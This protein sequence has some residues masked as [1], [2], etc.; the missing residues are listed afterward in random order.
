M[1]NTYPSTYSLA[2]AAIVLTAGLLCSTAS[3]ETWREH[4]FDD[5]RKGESDDG[6]VN[7]YAAADG[8]LRTVY[9]FDYNR[10]GSN[11][12]LY[13]C[14]HDNGYAPPAYI[15]MNNDGRFDPRFRWELLNE[16]SR[17]GTIADLNGDGWPEVILCGTMNGMNFGKLDSLV[18]YGDPK[19]YARARSTRLPTSSSH[20][21]V[22]IDVNND[23]NPDLAFAQGS[24][25]GVVVY[26][27]RDGAFNPTD[28]KTLGVGPVSW[29]QTAD[30][31]GDKR[32]DLLVLTGGRLLGFAVNGDGIE[33]D[34]SLDIDVRGSGRF[35]VADVDGDGLMDIVVTDKKNKAGGVLIYWGDAD[36]SF[37][38]RPP[39]LL[40]SVF[41]RDVAVA[42]L[43]R[44][45]HPDVVV[46]N[47]GNDN[48]DGDTPTTIYFG[49]G[50]G[51]DPDSPY[52]LQTRFAAGVS[53]ADFDGDG[54]E[55]LV[56]ACTRSDSSHNVSSYIYYN[57]EG[58]FSDS[59]RTAV[60][61][62]GA[63]QTAVGDVDRNGRP[64]VMFLNSVDGTKGLSDA[65]LYWND[66]EGHFTAERMSLLPIRDAFG[67]VAA[68]LNLDGSLDIVFANSYEYA[69]YREEGSYIYW[70][71]PAGTW[72]PDQRSLVPTEFAVSVIAADLN[73]DGWLDLVFGQLVSWREGFDAK[74]R[75]SPVFYGSPQGYSKERMTLL[76]VE[77]PRGVTVADLNKDG[78]IDII[79]SNLSYPDVP[80]YWG[81]ADGYHEDNRT[82]L[83]LPMKGSVT[84]NC[85]DLNADGWLDLV[86][87]GHEDYSN[88]KRRT[89]DRYSYILWGS[90][91]G[92][93][94]DRRVDLPTM[95]AQ[96]SAVA[97]FD[98]DG[99]LDLFIPSYT[100]GDK[101]RTWT[102]F[103][104]YN[105]AK[106]FSSSRRTGLLTDAGSGAVALDY[107]KDGWL[108]LAVACHMLPNGS[109]RANSFLFYGGANGFDDYNKLE[110]PTEGSHDMTYRDPGHIYHRRFEIAY[111]SGVHDAGRTRSV[112]AVSWSAK[113]PHGSSLRFQV[114]SAE[115][116]KDLDQAAWVGAG[117]ADSFIERPGTTPGIEVRGRFVQYRAVFISADGSNYPTLSEVRVE[118]QA[119]V[120]P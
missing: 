108:D 72:S 79:Y 59:D 1:K 15:Y 110:L 61:T 76:P 52:E 38:S 68:D 60:L 120:K 9:S 69:R 3:A 102:S 23:E 73:R 83:M 58:R 93:D 118:L 92:F 86:V 31:N 57:D 104:Y 80:I 95:G 116:Q 78:W 49:S 90:A 20:G 47:Y 105:D 96:G 107:N 87:I 14:S 117:G 55:D 45:G 100:N 112:G 94:M 119:D 26:L 99:R 37:S 27:N 56:V 19:G 64:D 51:F 65:R 35:R 81:S 17:G 84:L 85:A 89:A 36:R 28:L 8:T 13:V 22:A 109:H 42:D 114:R 113:T 106:G 70:G 39:T 74:D 111:T 48:A 41:S 34:A 77:D 97:D 11:D 46:A 24:G 91:E 29:M 88:P 75:R 40:P 25:P 115:D 32:E 7:L 67:H 101:T 16:G 53:V 6:G 43:N 21:V 63:V 103:L 33:S 62:L 50:S 66:G 71:G 82:K 30:F 98:K 18:Y 44:D 54:W 12:I 10:D 2:V 5:F 4:T